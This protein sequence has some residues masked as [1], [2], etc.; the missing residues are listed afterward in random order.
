MGA[1]YVTESRKEALKLARGDDETFCSRSREFSLD[2]KG[3]GPVA[4]AFKTGQEVI[5]RDPSKGRV[6]SVFRRGAHSSTD[7][8]GAQS[9]LHHHY[10]Y[11]YD[12]STFK[13]AA[14]AEEFGLAS[15]HFVPTKA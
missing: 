1:D 7:N 2:A 5:L 11:H 8:R 14:L 6:C 3:E 10:H 9:E 12:A 4:T 15:F 13:R